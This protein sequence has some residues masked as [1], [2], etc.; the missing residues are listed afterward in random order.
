M[1]DIKEVSKRLADRAEA[2]ARHL[3]PNGKKVGNEFKIGNIYGDAGQSLSICLSGEKVGFFCDFASGDRGDLLDLWLLARQ[4]PLA[5]ALSEAKHYLG[6]APPILMPQRASN[7]VKPTLTNCLS[8]EENIISSNPVK[9]YLVN[10]RKL[11]PETLHTFG[12]KAKGRDI[13]FPFY[14]DNELLQVKYLSID[15]S[16][17]K[18]QIRVEKNCQPVL[19]GW[20]VVPDHTRTLMITEGEIDAMSFYQYQLGY[21]VLSLPLG[22]GVGTQHTWIEHEFDNLSRFEEIYLCLDNDATGQQA[23][24]EIAERLGRHRCRIV[25]LPHKDANECL[26]KGISA[27]QMQR[28]IAEAKTCDPAEL[29]SASVFVDQVIEEFYPSESTPL[30]Y[31]PPWAKAKGKIRFRP[32]ELSVWSGINGHGKSQLLGHVVL[33]SMKQG[34]RVC[35]ASMELKPQKLLMRLTRQASA[36]DLPTQDYIHAIHEWYHGKLWM[37]DLIG[38]AKAERLLEVFKYTRQRYGVDVFVIDS[39]MKCGIDE[40]D[41][42]AQKA[43]IEQLC[44]FK[45]EHHCHI[46]IVIHPRKGMDESKAPSKLDVKGTGAMTDLADNCLAVWRNK[47]K[48]EAIRQCEIN[49]ESP[50]KDLLEQPDCLLI[51]DK[52]RN[53]DWEG[54]LGLFY[55]RKSFQYLNN[56]YQKPLRYVSFSKSQTHI[57]HLPGETHVNQAS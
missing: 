56:A 2:V 4:I 46:H 41:Y 20:Q 30:G 32:S 5:K 31:E 44:D 40:N 23:A 34:A 14:R 17:D 10:E 51:C 43:F 21:A 29:K 25:T 28:C 53:G 16:N 6:I 8:F 48:E 33:E 9:N 11:T 50:S 36:L 12:I 24:I 22:A 7:F 55:D 1:V 38:T 3:F 57:N 52:Q 35:I 42:N 13:V 47:H 54:K 27:E 26:Q 37:F 19:F 15:R 49:R 18:K 39:F 45:N